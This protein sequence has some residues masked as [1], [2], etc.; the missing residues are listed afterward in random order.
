MGEQHKQF[1]DGNWFGDSETG[2]RN[3]LILKLGSKL[4]HNLGQST[5][6]LRN[7]ESI[8]SGKF[9]ACL[10]IYAYDKKNHILA[11]LDPTWIKDNQN[12]SEVMLAIEGLNNPKIV[13]FG[14]IDYKKDLRPPR[15][16]VLEVFRDYNFEHIDLGIKKQGDL[17][18]DSFYAHKPGQYYHVVHE[19]ST[20]SRM[21]SLAKHLGINMRTRNF[22]G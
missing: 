3:N 21:E 9:D 11:H 19:E 14:G 15:N 8:F 7:N 6:I 12:I 13:V 22:R 16:I 17:T 18:V 10:G 5:L 20:K 2:Y 1:V 4:P